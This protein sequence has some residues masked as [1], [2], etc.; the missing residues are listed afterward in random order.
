MDP[1]ERARAATKQAVESLRAAKAAERQA[2]NQRAED[3]Q[4]R[5]E[6]KRRRARAR[7]RSVNQT[8]ERPKAP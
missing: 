4:T 7:A 3:A 8:G 2:W 6:D 5:P 1:L